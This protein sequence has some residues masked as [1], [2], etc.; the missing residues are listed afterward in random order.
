MKNLSGFL[1][2]ARIKVM[3]CCCGVAL[4]SA[5]GGGNADGSNGKVQLASVSYSSPTGSSTLVA[6]GPASAGALTPAVPDS[7]AAPATADFGMAGY[8]TATPAGDSQDG[9][10]AN[11][12]N[13]AD[14]AVQAPPAQPLPQQ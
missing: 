4:L 14:P 1:Q 5:C 10:A 12:A 2:G 13:P 11:G 3:L 9:A 7:T 8:G 6:A